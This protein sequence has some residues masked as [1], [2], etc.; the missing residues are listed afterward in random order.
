MLGIA[1][2]VF[3]SSVTVAL[4]LVLSQ[5]V[6]RVAVQESLRHIEH[7]EGEAETA[8]E[9]A[10]AAPLAERVFMPLRSGAVGL[11]RRFTPQD[12]VAKTRHKLV[13]A[14]EHDPDL[15]DKYLAKRLLV[16]AALPVSWIMAFGVLK[17]DRSK[18]LMVVGLLALTAILGPSASLNRKIG[19]RRQDIQK[20]LPDVLDLLTI[21]VEAGLGFEQALDRTVDAVP[22]PLTEELGRMLGEMRAGARRS[23]ALRA[24]DQRVGVP[25]VHS[26]TLAILQADTFGVSITRVLRSQ[27][28][29]MRIR[30]RQMAQERAQ[31]APVKMLVPMVFCIFPSLFTVVLGPAALS[32]IEN[33]K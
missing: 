29:E 10:L 23:E 19:Q 16:L 14:G 1:M 20:S 12:Y 24:F 15:V 13:L 5:R 7:T 9:S 2:I 11:V 6:D 25:D 32:I 3:G 17:M 28:D 33:F 31:K 22:G 8:R 30:R 27:A 26:F 21:S 18:G 4:Y